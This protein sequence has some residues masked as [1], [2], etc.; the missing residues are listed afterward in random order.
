MLSYDNLN[1]LKKIIPLSVYLS[2]SSETI[3][4]E[5]LLIKLLGGV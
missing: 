2:L 4:K 1:S 5:T 3:P